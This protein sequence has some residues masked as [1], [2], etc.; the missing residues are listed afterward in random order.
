MSAI[1]DNKETIQS[2]CEHCM[3]T[4]ATSKAL[5]EH[6]SRYHRKEQ[7]ALKEKEKERRCRCGKGFTEKRSLKRH[8]K[9]CK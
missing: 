4:Y 3:K 5:C 9:K 2:V 8:E 6:I 1:L 7:L